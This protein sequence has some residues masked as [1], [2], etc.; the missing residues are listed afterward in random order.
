MDMKKKFVDPGLDFENWITGDLPKQLNVSA[1][2]ERLIKIKF[3]GFADYVRQL[4]RVAS[5]EFD[6]FYSTVKKK[7]EEISKQRAPKGE[8]AVKGHGILKK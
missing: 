6:V 4:E 8:K 1:S 3:G 5:K 7:F 2:K